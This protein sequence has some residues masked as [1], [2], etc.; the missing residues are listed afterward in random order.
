MIKG[1]KIMNNVAQV[2]TTRCVN[3]D[4]LVYKVMISRE[5]T[6][7]S[8]EYQSAYAVAQKFNISK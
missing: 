7:E 5:V 8:F 3:T 4:K 6:F 1:R 2:I